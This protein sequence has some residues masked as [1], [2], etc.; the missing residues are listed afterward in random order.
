M[1][2]LSQTSQMVEM[3]Q[4]PTHQAA[5]MKPCVTEKQDCCRGS[6]SLQEP[7][8]VKIKSGIRA[9]G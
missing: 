7:P 2:E 9:E 3:K 6:D 4:L 1:G 5:P 8:S